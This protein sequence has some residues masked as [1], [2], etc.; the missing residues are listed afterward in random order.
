MAG[1]K[2]VINTYR[3]PGLF[4]SEKGE[5]KLE[6]V[7]AN[8]TEYDIL[9]S[10]TKQQTKSCSQQGSEFRFGVIDLELGRS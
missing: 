6:K 8:L 9:Y 10:D 1:S 5:K 4:F 7:L 2:V 3:V